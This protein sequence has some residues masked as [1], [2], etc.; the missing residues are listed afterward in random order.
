MIWEQVPK[1]RYCG[2]NKVKLAVYDAV[3]IFNY[4][5]KAI[6]DMSKLLNIIPRY[7]TTELCNEINV[8]RKYNFIYKSMP[9]TRIKRKIIRNKRKTRNDK[10]IDTEGV[11]YEAGGY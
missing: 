1:S 11:T 6:L 8:T 2:I 4:G 5:C 10:N 9:S 7:Y 3:G